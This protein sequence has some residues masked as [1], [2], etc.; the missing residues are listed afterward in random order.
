MGAPL[1]LLFLYPALLTSLAQHN[2]TIFPNE[3]GDPFLIQIDYSPL[4]DQEI[5]AL[6]ANL[7][8]ITFTL[9][10]RGNPTNGQDLKLNDPNGVSASKWNTRRPTAV[11]TH[12]WQSKGTASVC[13]QIRDAFLDVMDINV[14]VVDWSQIAKDV[15][16]A[17]VAKSIPAVAEH[18][19]TFV[20]F[21]RRDSGL[22]SS[23]LKMIGH[24]LGAHVASIAAGRLSKTCLVSEVVALDP[25]GPMFDTN[26]PDSRVDRTHAKTVEVVHT[27]V[28]GLSKAIGTSDF[29]AN[30]GKQQP[31]C[32]GD[33][34]GNCA[35]SRS[36]EYYSS[37]L[38]HT[39]G[40][41]GTPRDGGEIKYMGGPTIDPTAHGSYDFKTGSKPPYTLDD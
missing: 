24:S 9:F 12:G 10:T 22:K 27:S 11:V 6:E 13:T 28:L 16:Y 26:G 1:P 29:Y 8:T 37:S 23:T 2:Y 31:G 4:N 21:M 14:I 18:V 7:D 38:I 34:L 19:A 36:Y 33:Y 35:H 20:N 17:Q 30:G 15:N 5:S 25:A 41:P 40:F 3:A 32:A 39:K